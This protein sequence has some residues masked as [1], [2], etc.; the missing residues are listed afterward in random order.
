MLKRQARAAEYQGR[1]LAADTLAAA[2]ALDR[3]REKHEAAAAQ[4]RALAALNERSAGDSVVRS[5]AAVGRRGQKSR[6]HPMHCLDL[7]AGSTLRLDATARPDVGDHRWDVRVLT[8][9]L[10]SAGS[11]PR[12]TYGSQ[13]GGR[14]R[15]QRIEIPAQDADCRLEVRSR[16]AADGG[17]QDDRSSVD[18]DTPSRLLIGFSD[19]SSP[20]SHSEDVLLS[21]TF[22][23]AEPG[24]KG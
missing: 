7:P 14:D 8:A 21:F 17:W 19:P 11:P 10:A 4:W 18:E 1:A 13:I 2:S 24:V 6:G 15:E 22:G 23:A 20:T 3:V 9:D 12:L 16:H 5:A